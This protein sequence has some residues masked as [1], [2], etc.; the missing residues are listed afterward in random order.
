M[1]YSMR[2]LMLCY[3]FPPLGGGGGRVVQGLATELVRRGHSV[4]LVTTGFRGLPAAEIIN[5]IHMS[6]VPAVRRRLHVCTMSEALSYLIA[7]LPVA[8]RLARRGCYDLD[9]THFIFPDG[10]LAWLVHRLTGLPYVITAH[11]SDVPGYNPDRLQLAHKV[12]A[13]LWRL[14]VRGARDVICPSH[15]LQ[16]L[17]L[18]EEPAARTVV[19]PNGIRLDSYAPTGTGRRGILIVTRMFER[20]GVQYALRAIQQLS[21][22]HEVR[23]AGDGPYLPALKHVAQQLG[24][25][26]EFIGWLDNGSARLREL[27]ETSSIFVFP[28]EG[29]NFPVVL[30]EAMAA[31][32]A[33]ITTE[34]T[35]CAEVV[36]D[37]ALLV[38]SRDAAAIRSALERLLSDEPLRRRLGDA[39]RKRLEERFSWA[40]VA[41]Q[42]LTLYRQHARPAQAAA[43]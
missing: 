34:E 26:V 8:L 7:A 20:K 4:D 38:P 12:L 10:C 29:E 27:Y 21:G 9:H 11:G 18:R 1:L 31:G 36:G 24:V 43:P 40:S 37:A 30:L 15:T 28:S 2:V 22:E 23:I 17:V 3:E 35:G 14:V 6:W 33:I 42:H 16:R 32:L 41:D 19:I 25:R 13:P 5:G 39:A